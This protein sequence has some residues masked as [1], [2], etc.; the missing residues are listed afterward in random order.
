MILKGH[1]MLVFREEAGELIEVLPETLSED[2]RLKCEAAS[3]EIP[4]PVGGESIA[5]IGFDGKVV[6]GARWLEE[7]EQSSKSGGLTVKE[8]LRNRKKLEELL[9]KRG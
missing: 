3:N 5:V 2:L 6:N 7:W 1:Q 4:S 9:K 8:W